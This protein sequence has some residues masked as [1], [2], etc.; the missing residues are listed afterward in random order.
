MTEPVR[1]LGKS[2]GQPALGP[3][4]CR[5]WIDPHHDIGRG[6]AALSKSPRHRLLFLGEHNELR[7]RRITCEAQRLQQIP[8]ITNLMNKRTAIRRR[9][10]IGQQQASCICRISIAPRHT[11]Q[12]RQ[13]RRL[14][15]ILKQNGQIEIL[16]S[17]LP[18]QRPFT[19]EPRMAS[20]RV[21]G[22]H[23]RQCRM[24]GKQIGYPRLDQQRDLRVREQAPQSAQGRLT[25]HGIAKPIGSPH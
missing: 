22:Q 10:W 20:V 2:F 17:Q 11:S 5:A 19:G 21:V 25:H 4:K 15:R 7:C 24:A 9:D 16:P 12:K 18:G 13:E 14:E 23:T 3:A 1:D 6:Y 8:I